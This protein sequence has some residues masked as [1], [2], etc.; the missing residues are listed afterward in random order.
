MTAV[1]GEMKQWVVGVMA[2]IY[3][4]GNSVRAMRMESA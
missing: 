4:S 3:Y 1:A 2:S